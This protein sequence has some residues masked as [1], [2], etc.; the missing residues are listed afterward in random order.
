ML[1]RLSQL[2]PLEKDRRRP[3]A[4]QS[5]ESSQA[6]TADETCDRDDGPQSRLFG[7]NGLARANGFRKPTTDGNLSRDVS[8]AMVKLLKDYLGRGASHAHAYIREDLV[9][10]VLRG[11]MTK[12][13]R[14]LA[15][16]GEEGLVRGVRQALRGKFREDANRIVERLTGRRVAA[17]LSDH[18]IDED[19]VFQAFVLEPA[20]IASGAQAEVGGRAT[21]SPRL[22]P[23][24]PRGSAV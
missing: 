24:G 22:A 16:A 6:L 3:M 1:S 21:P 11:T 2:P 13:E 12:A 19:I 9:V 4:T 15:D 5:G 14:T 7:A 20:R 10:V 8:G 17:F 23:P 18:D